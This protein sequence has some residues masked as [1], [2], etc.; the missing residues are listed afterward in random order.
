MNHISGQLS[1]KSGERQAGRVASYN[2]PESPTCRFSSF[3]MTS[4]GPS[5]FNFDTFL[6]PIAS[7]RPYPNYIVRQKRHSLRQKS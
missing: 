3:V 7:A 1:S 6:F 2:E 4:E 5:V